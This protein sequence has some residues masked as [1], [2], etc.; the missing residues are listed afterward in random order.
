MG[1]TE[2]LQMNRDGVSIVVVVVQAVLKRVTEVSA[3]KRE[4][5]T[6]SSKELKH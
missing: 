3:D 5:A 4:A 1:Q 6:Q 2:L